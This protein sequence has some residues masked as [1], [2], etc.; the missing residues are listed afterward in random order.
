MQTK[1]NAGNQQ[2]PSDSDL[3]ENQWH[4]LYTQILEILKKDCEL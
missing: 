1:V 2:A 3:E 4:G